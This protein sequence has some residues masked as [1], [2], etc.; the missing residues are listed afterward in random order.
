MV[1]DF[2]KWDYEKR[3]RE[4]EPCE[5]SASVSRIPLPPLMGGGSLSFHYLPTRWASSRL[6]VSRAAYDLVL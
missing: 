5:T 3:S 2:L 4:A 1:K 6:S